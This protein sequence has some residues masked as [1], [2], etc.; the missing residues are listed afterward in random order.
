MRC[1]HEELVTVKRYGQWREMLCDCGE[2]IW[3]EEPLPVS[4]SIEIQRALPKRQYEP[5][6]LI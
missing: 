4:S 5:R 3:R 6:C 1:P 2:M